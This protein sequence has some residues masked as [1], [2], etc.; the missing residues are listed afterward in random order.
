MG[1]ILICVKGIN[2]LKHLNKVKSKIKNA[3]DENH[4]THQYL[5]GAC[6]DLNSEQ[7]DLHIEVRYD[8]YAFVE[9]RLHLHEI[10]M[11]DD[12]SEYTEVKIYN[13]AQLH[14]N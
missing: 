13:E 12:D 1:E 10:I 6:I 11:T 5:L 8:G 14:S 7:D 9:D 3:L 2:K 4:L